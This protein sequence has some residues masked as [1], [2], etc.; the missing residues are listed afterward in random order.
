MNK[1]VQWVLNLTAGLFSFVF[2]LVLFFPFD[3]LITGFLGKVETQSKGAWRVTVGEIDA[4]VIFKSVFKDFRI[5]QMSGG[6]DEVVADFPEVKVGF[7]Y[8]PLIAGQVSASFTAKGQKGRMDGKL[9]LSSDEFHLD[10]KMKG[11]QFSDIRY[12][13]NWLKLPLEGALDGA[14]GL[15]LYPGQPSKNSGDIDLKLKNLKISPARI[16]PTAGF[17]LDLPET[18]LSDEKGGTVRVQMGEGKIELKEVNFP[19]EDLVLNLSGRIQLG[20]KAEMSRLAINGKFSLSK[21]L[22][23]AFPFV[24]MIE[25]QKGEDGSYPLTLSGRLN[26]PRVQIGTF[27]LL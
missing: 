14:I 17:D 13:A 5:H 26:K 10:A 18:I 7:R 21:K 11:M 6:R 1:M 9:K 19:G 2:F 23:D 4:G 25:G 24:V 12:V 3:S 22:Q 20:K 27:D 8:L 15:A 16:T